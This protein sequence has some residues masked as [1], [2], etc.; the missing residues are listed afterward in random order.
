MRDFKNF[1][2]KLAAMVG[3]SRTI[4]GWG[5]NDEDMQDHKWIFRAGQIV[6]DALHFSLN[7]VSFP[8]MSFC[9]EKK[10]KSTSV[11]SSLVNVGPE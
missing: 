7:Q 1:H 2:D 6:S 9:Q 3:L 11:A 5:V 10:G 4:K 8:Q